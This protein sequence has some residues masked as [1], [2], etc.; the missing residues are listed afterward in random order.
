MSDKSPRNSSSESEFFDDAISSN[1]IENIIRK[2]VDAKKFARVRR[3][4]EKDGTFNVVKRSSSFN[5][6]ADYNV[7]LEM[8]WVSF[9]AL[10]LVVYV[11]SFA[12][13]GA[14]IY[15][16]KDALKY[17]KPIPKPSKDET[18]PAKQ[19]DSGQREYF[20]RERAMEQFLNITECF[21]GVNNYADGVLLAIETVTTIGYGTKFP[22]PACP[23]A[24]LT[25]MLIVFWSLFLSALFS[26]IFLARFATSFG[27]SKIRFSQMA[28]ISKING[29]LYFMIRLA[30]PMASGNDIV[31]V[32][33]FACIKQRVDDGKITARSR[34]NILHIGCMKFSYDF[35]HVH[36]HFPLMW[37]MVLYH[38]IDKDS[39]LYRLDPTK[40]SETK[41]EIIVKV[42]G[43]RTG[44]GG[45]ILS[46]T[47]YINKEII[48]GGY[49]CPNSVL[50]RV[51][52]DKGESINVAS[53]GQKDIDKII[54]DDT[55]AHSAHK[56][57]EMGPMLLTEAWFGE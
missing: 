53:I 17:D 15:S 8:K 39:P 26:G 27:S 24:I 19:D 33:S 16:L 51:E 32:N 20:G 55:P 34:V 45:T 23:E 36:N 25:S 10:S 12:A 42:S 21:L 41:L 3:L 37:P 43:V 28:A 47:S 40:L 13:F 50:F 14:L 5:F 38:K 54:P 31:E 18:T 56:L 49:F 52:N 1:K 44:T 7:L 9:L 35:D 46:N 30:D 11:L 29:N 48:W 22:D 57:D 6:L 2:S 4:V